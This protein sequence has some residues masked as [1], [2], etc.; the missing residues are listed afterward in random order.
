M[1][2]EAIVMSGLQIS[3]DDT[4][5]KVSYFSSPTSFQADVTGAKG[6]AVGALDVSVYGTEV[7]LSELTTPGFARF[8][9]QDPTNYVTYGIRD[10]ETDVFYPLGEI[11][12]GES[13][14]LR[15]S[16]GVGQV[17][18]GTGTGTGTSGLSDNKLTFYADTAACHV[19][20]EVFEK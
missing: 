3:K 12:P 20:I 14:V 6:P 8:Y 15:L 13:Y 17:W 9:N 18:V 1:T 2:S 19:L 4:S 7:N 11:L 10:P 5:G 16:R